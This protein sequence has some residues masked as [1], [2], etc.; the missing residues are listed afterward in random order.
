[1]RNREADTWNAR[2]RLAD[3]E[4][5]P[6][7]MSLN[8]LLG[9]MQRLQREQEQR[10][11]IEQAAHELA[12]TLRRTRIG[13]PYVPPQYTGTIF[14]VVLLELVT[15]Y[16]RGGMSGPSPHLADPR[17]SNPGRGASRPSQY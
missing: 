4:M 14:D 1:M 17:Q 6:L 8:M 11:R 16:Q 15:W 2:A 12:I 3:D 7:A 9:Q 10:A 13:G 5:Q